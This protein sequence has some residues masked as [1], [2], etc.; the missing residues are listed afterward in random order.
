LA[1]LSLT[2]SYLDDK[3]PSGAD[4]LHRALPTAMSEAREEVE[5]REI[6]LAHPT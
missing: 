5:E 3:L 1:E 2:L 6:L 4:L